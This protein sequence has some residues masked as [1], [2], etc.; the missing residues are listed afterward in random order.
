M[1]DLTLTT[2]PV[3]EVTAG[4]EPTGRGRALGTA[5]FVATKIA[6]ALVSLLLVV[7]LGFFLFRTLPG[8]PVRSLTLESHSSPEQIAHLRAEWRMDEP[9]FQQFLGYLRDLLHG[10]FGTSLRYKQPVS[11]LIATRLGPTL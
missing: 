6:G 8:N 9:L 1:T 4:G 2:D 7:V 10:D 3:A 5:R 11:D